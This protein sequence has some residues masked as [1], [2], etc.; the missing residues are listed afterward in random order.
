MRRLNEHKLLREYVRQSLL[1]KEDD[2][3][4]PSG[5]GYEAGLGGYYDE[6]A[7]VAA[8]GYRGGNPSAL[9]KTF[10]TP[11]TD[12][13][14][15]A[16]ASTKMVAANSVAMLQVAF[17]ALISTLIPFIGA[18]YD[19]IFD[20]RDKR[21][22]KVKDDYKEVFERTDEALASNDAKFL[23][24]LANPAVFMG[25]SAALKAPAATKGL[26]SVATGG[27]SDDAIEKVKDKWQTFHDKTL[28]G[29]KYDKKEA[30]K[31]KAETHDEF[32]SAIKASLGRN[33][34]ILRNKQVLKEEEKSVE[35]AK[36]PAKKPVE[37]KKEFDE[38]AFFK[39]MLADKSVVKALSEVIKANPQMKE[40]QGK[41]AA[42]EDETLKQSEQMAT[43]I[44]GKIKTFDDVKRLA[45]NDPKAKKSLAEIEK[46]QD[47][48]EKQ[49]AIDT[50]SKNISDA[51]KQTFMATL[52][53]R[54]KMFPKDSEQ[55]KK[56]E[57][58]L[59]K[60]KSL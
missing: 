25:A 3:G 52:G 8:A 21:V 57:D 60:I 38:K 6:G 17:T 23:A 46:I 7:A 4:A 55:Y 50:L 43:S 16:V 5:G 27:A 29:E 10:I 44:I 54:M 56:Y 58:A 49:K 39:E 12:V 34:S 18:R 2:Y 9:I 51:S 26:L 19:K 42:V 13:F 36:A 47:P 40:I 11:F 1:L 31:K 33:E 32:I 45:A 15:T 35:K 14:K 22:Q 30:Q 59:N 20:A 24:F 37:K 48:K 41:L 53:A 28:A